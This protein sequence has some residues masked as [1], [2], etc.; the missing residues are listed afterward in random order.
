M[1]A[2]QPMSW[3]SVENH[4]AFSTGQAPAPFVDKA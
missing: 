4:A 1:A 2:I 3:R